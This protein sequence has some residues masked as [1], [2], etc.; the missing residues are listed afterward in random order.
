MEDCL[1]KQLASVKTDHLT[2]AHSHFKN[3]KMKVFLLI[4]ASAI[5]ISRRE[6]NQFLTREKRFA[7]DELLPAS[8]ERECVEGD[9]DFNELLEVTV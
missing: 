6:A 7:I 2:N 3:L 1:Q 9:C 5:E 8:F 4:S